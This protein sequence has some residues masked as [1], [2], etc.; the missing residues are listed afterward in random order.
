MGLL[1]SIILEVIL[2]IFILIGVGAFI[3]RK[4]KLNLGTLSRVITFIMLPAVAFTN[5]YESQISGKMLGAIISFWI[6]QCICLIGLVSILSKVAKFDKGLSSTFKNSIVLNNSGNFGLPISQL[7]FKGDPIGLS[8]QIIIMT[9][10]NLLT[11]TYGLINSV[12]A[13]AASLKDVLKE[14][15]KIPVIYALL[16][17]LGLNYFNVKIPFFLWN[18]IESITNAF[19]AIA[20]ITLGA[21]SAFLKL[22]KFTLPLVLSLAGRLI[23]S[24]IIAFLI[25]HYLNLDGIIAQA[26]FIASALPSSRNSAQFALEYGNHPEYAAQAVIMSTLLSSMT[27]TL[28]VYLAKTI[29]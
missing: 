22:T 10:Q 20:L 17:G 29:F 28:V 19:L 27:V 5:M 11:Y 23:I 16:L 26:L 12:S 2:P 14:F 6:I 4:F 3:H 7:V 9:L 18:P 15:M 24:P 21:Q 13:N 8:V 25:I 1:L